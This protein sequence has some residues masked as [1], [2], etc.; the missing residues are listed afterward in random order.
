MGGLC[1]GCIRRPHQGT[2]TAPHHQVRADA[3][4][5]KSLDHTEMRQTPGAT[6]SEN[7]CDGLFFF[8]LPASSY[9]LFL[10][11]RLLQNK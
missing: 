6:A 5:L 8:S 9:F 4:I 2:G 7:Q 1:I 3:C 11:I 10:M